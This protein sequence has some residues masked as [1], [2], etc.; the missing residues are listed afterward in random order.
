[1]GAL[2][3]CIVVINGVDQGVKVT[4]NATNFDSEDCSRCAVCE[5]HQFMMARLITMPGDQDLEIGISQ[6]FE[7]NRVR[8][9]VFRHR[10]FPV[11]N[12]YN[13]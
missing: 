1:M 12:D 4:C 10:E 7:A 2:I 9:A 11:I 8:Q 5:D 6:R 13:Y 3:G